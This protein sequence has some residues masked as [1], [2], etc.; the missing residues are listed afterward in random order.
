MNK[1][2][3]SIK[4]LSQLYLF[5]MYRSGT[6]VI[7][8]SLAGENKIAFASDPIRP[9]FSFY[10][11]ALQ[12]KIG[13]GQVEKSNRPFNDYF[14]GDKKYLQ[15]LIK[16]NFSEEVYA[17]NLK[18]IR[19]QVIQ[20]GHLYSPKF[21]HNLNKFNERNSL[22]YSD[23][24][25]L[26][27]EIILSTYGHSST[28]LV[29]LKEVWSIEMAF[30][31]INLIG[32]KANIIIVIRDPLDVLASSISGSGNYSLLSLARQWRKQIVFYN[33]LKKK[34][35]NQVD[36]INYEDFCSKP[37]NTLRS[38]IGKMVKEPTNYFNHLNLL[39]D[40][41]ESWTKNTSY[42]NINS[43]QNI[44]ENSIGKYKDI[45]T[46]EEIEWMIYLTHMIS[47]KRYNRSKN[48]PKMPDNQFPKRNI[49]KSNIADW[50]KLDINFLETKNLS[51]ELN[52]E[53][54]RYDHMKFLFRNGFEENNLTIQI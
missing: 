25:S 17:S 39:D 50:A 16:S 26:Y 18:E 15:N 52:K 54:G 46:N 47:Y 45:L 5:G 6:T 1:L 53:Q 20:Q 44:D 48:I 19:A 11:T 24:L 12:Q 32:E 34:Y 21:I 31:I 8:R 43:S 14:K 49:N 3:N 30:P 2:N 10:R 36:M 35:P 51:N 22:K 37:I 42:K 9:F 23:E 40:N 4:N 7:A 29:G 41:G 33:L 27:L 13:L 28:N 38:I